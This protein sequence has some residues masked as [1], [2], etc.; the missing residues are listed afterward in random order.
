MA[1]RWIPTDTRWEV[2]FEPKPLELLCGSRADR[3]QSS[4]HDPGPRTQPGQNAAGTAYTSMNI[5]AHKICIIS[6]LLLLYVRVLDFNYNYV[7]TVVPTI[8]RI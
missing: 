1:A 6:V 2:G 8:L 5:H 7:L 4:A 3:F